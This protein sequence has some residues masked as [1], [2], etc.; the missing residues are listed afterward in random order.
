MAT[1]TANFAFLK[2]VSSELFD[3]ATYDSNLDAID[4]AIN[5]PG[6]TQTKLALGLQA[7]AEMPSS[8]AAGSALFVAMN[9]ASFTFKAGRRYLIEWTAGVVNNTAGSSNAPLAQIQSC[10]VT[11]SASLTTGLTELMGYNLSFNANGQSVRANPKRRITYTTDTTLQI[12]ATLNGA[13]VLSING[14]GGPTWPMQ[15]AIYD[16]GKQF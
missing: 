2:P 1:P 7:I 11:D 9:I 12:K 15:L 8:T 6:P 13:G 10:A 4:S 5:S 3:V 14:A 16:E